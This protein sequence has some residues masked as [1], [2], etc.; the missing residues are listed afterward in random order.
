MK[1]VA[2]L[3]AIAQ[4]VQT[5]PED[6]FLEL[7]MQ[8]SYGSSIRIE[9]TRTREDVA[10]LMEQILEEKIRLAV[11]EHIHRH[12]RLHRYFIDRLVDEAFKGKREE[13][14]QF[15][16]ADVRYR[17]PRNPPMRDFVKSELKKMGFRVTNGTGDALRVRW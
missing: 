9:L 15:I 13:E 1:L 3:R 8:R 2:I 10:V 12:P 17:R 5:L 11:A 6:F 7:G 14:F 16:P 4:T